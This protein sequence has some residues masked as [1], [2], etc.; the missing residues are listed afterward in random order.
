MIEPNASD[1][2]PPETAALAGPQPALL[3]AERARL[4]IDEAV[5]IDQLN[6]VARG[7][8]I[9]C[10]GDVDVLFSALTGV[11]LGLR[12][13]HAGPE[14]LPGEVH[15]IAGMLTVAGRDV[16]NRSHLAVAGSAPLD[17][18]LPNAWTVAE[19]VTWSARL[20]GATRRV[21]QDLAAAAL[22]QV[23]LAPAASRAL[24]TLAL[25]ERR[26]LVLAHA[27]VAGPSVL[28]AEAPLAGLDGPAAAFVTAA[29]AGAT[30]NRAA[31]LSATR[32]D[33][34]TPEGVLAREATHVIVLSGGEVALE[35]S[36][37]ELFAGVHVYALTLRSNVEPF[38]AELAA[39][40]I[41]LRGG[42]SRFSVAL[43]EGMTTR[44]I[45]ASANRAN[46]A[47]V[48]LLPIIR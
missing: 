10:T 30:R 2:A 14:D 6:L 16:S 21:A 24:G 4:A 20:T 42:P 35:G 12:N 9:L 34:G 18:P 44:E 36:A 15:V 23:G 13:R 28:I 46:A 45:L 5:A 40:G 3:H 41:A 47:L 33:P 31:I 11:P 25:P 39:R 1:A 8:R 38:R 22:A 37:T 48:E 7:E 27:I 17:P 43:Q 29:I 32:I 26:A 19:Y